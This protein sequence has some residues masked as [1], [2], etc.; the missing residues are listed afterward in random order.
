MQAIVL[1]G[2]AAPTRYSILANT[3]ANLE[4]WRRASYNMGDV[5]QYLSKVR[6]LLDHPNIALDLRIRRGQ[7]FR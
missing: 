7:D 4:M 1:P 6:T 2:P 5:E 3:T